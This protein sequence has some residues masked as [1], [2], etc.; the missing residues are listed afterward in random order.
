MEHAIQ[1][2][3]T[4]QS[5]ARNPELIFPLDID[6][7][8]TAECRLWLAIVLQTVAEYETALRKNKPDLL[9]KL[10]KEVKHQ[11]FINICDLAGIQHSVV[12]A[13]LELA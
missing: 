3:L 5:T 9:Q 12:L 8:T 10:A 11:W 1:S 7:A 2:A 13:R 6:Y 4:V